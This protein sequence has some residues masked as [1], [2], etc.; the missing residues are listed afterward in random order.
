MRVR[1]LL[2][3]I[4]CIA[5]TA[6]SKNGND[7]AA[8]ACGTEIAK[9]MGNK[10]YQVDLND[11]ANHAKTE[12]ADTVVMHSIVVFDKGLST[13]YRQTYECRARVDNT[14][15]ASVL[16]LQF[17]WNTSDLKKPG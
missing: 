9:Q 1:I 2:I 11:L 14:G 13:E 12:S 15:K 16:Y 5:A 6:C 8:K 10:N 4:L 17:N 3:S 7:A